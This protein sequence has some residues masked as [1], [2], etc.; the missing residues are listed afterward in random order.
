MLTITRA[1]VDFLSAHTVKTH[2]KQNPPV[3]QKLKP[4]T[5]SALEIVV[6]RRKHI[7][8]YV[9]SQ[10]FLKFW[11]W[12]LSLHLPLGIGHSNQAF[13]KLEHWAKKILPKWVA[14]KIDVNH[15][16]ALKQGLSLGFARN[17]NMNVNC[18]LQCRI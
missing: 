16:I 18:S 5:P 17:K 8:G 12:S 1:C 11:M 9:I 2:K 6:K 3:C 13:Y 15:C 10:A 7:F 4:F 14:L